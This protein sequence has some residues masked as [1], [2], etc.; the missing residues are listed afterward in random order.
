MPTTK[1]LT[2]PD[3]ELAAAYARCRAIHRKYDPSFYA[4]CLMLPPAKRPYVDALYAHARLLDQIVDDPTA[5]DPAEKSARLDQRIAAYEQ[6]LADGDSTDPVLKAAAHTARTWDI[7]IEHFHAF[8]DTMRSDLTVTDYAT[9][10]DLLVYMYG[11]AALLGLQL[12][13]I[14]EPL[15]PSAAERSTAVG[16]A[17]QLTN[18]LRDI[19]E[20]LGR[21]RLYLPQ[22]EMKQFGVG[23]A[24]FEAR[25]MT[26]GIREL[27]AFE[28]RRAREY[29]AD[30]HAAVDLLHPASRECVHTALTL[31]AGILD[32]LEQADYQIFGVRHGFNK[33]KSL[34]IA[35]PAYLRARRAWRQQ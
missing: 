15:D 26:D 19:D 23:R 28:T 34:R 27:L 14:L 22:D 17:L 12:V 31:Y 25:Q 9:Y 4:G 1:D 20:D 6:A 11:A 3:P 7:P 2:A 24:D 13:P 35:A 16:N 10:D 33:A 29:Y 8:T 5:V 32:S 30:A 18:I 21:G